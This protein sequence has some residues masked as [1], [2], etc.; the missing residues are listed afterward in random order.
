MMRLR[1]TLITESLL[2]TEEDAAEELTEEE[3]GG[4]GEGG[5][6]AGKLEEAGG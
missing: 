2:G 3:A 1:R 4:V 6:E 5:W